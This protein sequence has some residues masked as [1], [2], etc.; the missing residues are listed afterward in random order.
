MANTKYGNV[1]RDYSS[2]VARYTMKKSKV[3]AKLQD[4]S[5]PKNAEAIAS[6]KAQLKQISEEQAARRRAVFRQADPKDNTVLTGKTLRAMEYDTKQASKSIADIIRK[7]SKFG[8]KT[9]QDRSGKFSFKN[10]NEGGPKMYD[11]TQLKKMK[12]ETFQ[13]S[14]AGKITQEATDYLLKYFDVMIEEAKGED[15]NT[16]VTDYVAACKSGDESKKEELKAK[17]DAAS[18]CKNAK[19]E[20]EALREKLSDK[21]KAFVDELNEEICGNKE[22]KNPEG[23]SEECPEG[24]EASGEEPVQESGEEAGGQPAAGSDPAKDSGNP[25][26]AAAD[27]SKKI[28]KGAD[29]TGSDSSE[30]FE[31][32][33][34]AASES[35]ISDVG[36][37][38]IIEYVTESVAAGEM[39]VDDAVLLTELVSMGV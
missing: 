19:K 22:E 7:L 14:A 30:A 35:T 25:P 2:G 9:D 12:L 13:E 4:Q 34:S 36:R 20:L 29:K 18:D 32:L 26:K 15:I 21:E 33:L 8:V 5:D 38:A 17:I 16:L 24:A 37:N 39:D 27:L 6:L 11:V 28:Q 23:K 31:E 3:E 10:V 1:Q